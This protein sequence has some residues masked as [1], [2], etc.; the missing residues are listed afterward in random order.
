MKGWV[1]I[2]TNKAMPNLLKVGYSTKDPELRANELHTT[3][4]PHRY[5]VEYDAL[6]EQPYKVE[7]RT[8]ALLALFNEKKEWF[9]CDIITAINAI[10]QAA[11]CS[12]IH[13][14][15]KNKV[16]TKIINI[17]TPIESQAQFDLGELYANAQGEVRDNKKAIEW[18]SKAAEQGLQSAQNYLGYAYTNG[19]GV[20]KDVS[21]GIEWFRKATEQYENIN[22]QNKFVTTTQFVDKFIE[23]KTYELGDILSDG[24]IVYFLDDST[25]HGM[26]AQ[27]R[28][29]SNRLTWEEG[30]IFANTYGQDWHLPTKEE[31]ALL[32]AKR[33]IVGWFPNNYYWSSTEV[34]S[35]NAWYQS[36]GNGCQ[37]NNDK[38][39]T[40]LVRAVRVF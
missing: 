26:A 4:V 35:G 39:N 33:N 15:I 3:G 16:A 38:T 7:Q 19:Q 1:Y 8:H 24:G 30:K 2:I 11:N 32:Y 12:I 6:V 20:P 29:E 18:V 21:K 27:P 31:L 23:I 37:Y 25:K 28:N 22:T 10:R 40:F 9:K 14:S 13:E 34:G 5:V 17:G 36:F